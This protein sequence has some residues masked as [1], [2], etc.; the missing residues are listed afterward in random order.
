SDL[1]RITNQEQPT[2]P[3]YHYAFVVDAVEGL[4]LVNV[5][6]FADLE[7]RNNNLERALTWNEGGIL[8]GARHITIGGHYLYIAA[9]AGLVILN[10]DDP[11]KPKVARVV[12]A[13]GVRASALQFRY[14]F[15]SDATGLRVI[16]V[17]VPEAARLLSSPGS[18]VPLGHAQ[19]IYLARTYAYVANGGDGLAIV[20]IER[21]EL[22]RLYQMFNAEG[23]LNDARDVVVA[24]TNASLFA[25]VADGRNGLKVLQLTS[26]A[27]QPKFYGFSPEPKPQLIAWRA[28]ASP[29][30]SLSKGLDRDRAVDETGG[31]IAI[32]GRIGARPF[33]L[34]EMRKMYLRPDGTTWTVSDA[35][36]APNFRPA[37]G[38]DPS[39]GSRAVRGPGA[40]PQEASRK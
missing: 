16:D 26:P 18:V 28:T 15:V 36:D 6:T 23:A 8:R 10:V 40:K 24:S 4:I 22:P 27:S 21:P 12:S 13:P 2:H 7:P 14:L 35:V 17:T 38:Q 32:V 11:M 34:E 25:Y 19:R 9:D 3:I 37:Q 20:D 31:Q 5:D 1:M 30:L 33:T 39:R 29:A